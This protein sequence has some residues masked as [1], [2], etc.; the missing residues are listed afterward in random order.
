M[1]GKKHLSLLGRRKIPQEKKILL[2]PRSAFLPYLLSE[3]ILP[4]SELDIWVFPGTQFYDH[5][6]ASVPL[7]P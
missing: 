4:A 6:C 1:V 2:S 3:V 5:F 7:V